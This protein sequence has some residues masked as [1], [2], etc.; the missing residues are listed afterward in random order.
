[1]VGN[2][3][4]FTIEKAKSKGDRLAQ[5]KIRFHKDAKSLGISLSRQRLFWNVSST[6]PA[7]EADLRRLLSEFLCWAGTRLEERNIE[8]MKEEEEFANSFILTLSNT[9]WKKKES[10]QNKLETAA[11]FHLIYKHTPWGWRRLLPTIH[12]IHGGRFSPGSKMR[13]GLG[14][15]RNKP[16]FLPISPAFQSNCPSCSWLQ[17]AFSNDD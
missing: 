16:P 13:V 14:T 10:S 3:G 8:E 17:E 11:P 9:V 6:L 2:R 15:P 5:V 7:G 12:G 4:N 1:M